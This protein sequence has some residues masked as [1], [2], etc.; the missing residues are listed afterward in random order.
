MSSKPSVRPIR[1]RTLRSSIVQNLREAIQ[2]H[3]LAPGTRLS[4]SELAAQL[5]VSHSTVREAL[6]QLT[7]ERLVISAPHRGFFVAGFTLDDVIDL[8]E[9]RGLLE[10]RIAEAVATMLTDEDLAQLEAAALSMGRIQL[11]EVSGFWDA[12][13]A[14]HEII[15]QRCSKTVP[16][17]LWNSLSSRLAMLEIL[18][19][20]SFASRFDA[21][22]DFHLTYLE[23]LRTRD[24]ARARRAAEEHYRIPA[25][26]LR[27]TQARKESE[28]H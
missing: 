12:D 13:R 22:Q 3:R 6:H 27:G 2:Q 5:G 24:P 26:R 1:H 20:D 14:F 28:G 19:H 9:M 7:H 10:G 18:H 8:L 21:A 4:D 17:E 16:V 23:E 15:V 11:S 25:E